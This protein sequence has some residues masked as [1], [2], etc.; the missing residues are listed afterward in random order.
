[1]PYPHVITVV[2]IA[3]AAAMVVRRTWFV[4]AMCAALCVL[5]LWHGR[6]KLRHPVVFTRFDTGLTLWARDESPR[7]A[8][9]LA[10]PYYGDLRLFSQRA[11]VVD[12]KSPPM[13]MAEVETWF[14]RLSAS[15]DADRLVTIED[16]WRRWDALTPPRLVAIAQ[17][18][19]ADYIVIDKARSAARLD[20]QIAYEDGINIVY[21]VSR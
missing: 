5:A 12:D 6:V 19:R 17:H 11:V 2:M 13:Y 4:Q 8:L 20:L 14:A 1:V 21:A 15:V 7:D 9:F 3:A 10:P 18:F 16:G